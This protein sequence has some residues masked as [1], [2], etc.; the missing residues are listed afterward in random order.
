MEEIAMDMYDWR[1]E[2][3]LGIGEYRVFI[4]GVHAYQA[5]GLG[6]GTV[7]QLHVHPNKRI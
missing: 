4:Q 6:L 2:K 1:I 5:L 3:Q 7:D